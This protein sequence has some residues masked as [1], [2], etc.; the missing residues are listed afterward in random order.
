MLNKNIFI[1]AV[2]IIAISAIL[3]FSNFY[4]SYQQLADAFIKISITPAAIESTKGVFPIGYVQVVKNDGTPQRLS[5]EI[6]IQL[7]SSNPSVATVPEKLVIPANQDVANFEITI[8]HD[9]ETEISANLQNQQVAQKLVVGGTP[10]I[11]PDVGLAINM[12]TTSMNV[13]SEMPASVSLYKNGTAWKS[14]RDLKISLD[15]EKSLLQPESETITIKKGSSYGT[16]TIKS[17]GKTGNAFFKAYSNE[18]GLNNVSKIRVGSSAPSGLIV[19]VFP[20]VLAYTEKY[21]D[22]FVGLVDSN[23]SPTVATEDTKFTFFSNYTDLGESIEE[24][25]APHGPI[26]RKGQFGYHLTQKFTFPSGQARLNGILIG[27]SAPDLG[28]AN[29]TLKIVEP[30]SADSDKAKNKLVKIFTPPKM[31]G[32]TTSILAYQIYAVEDDEDDETKKIQE[33]IELTEE[34]VA[35]AEDTLAEAEDDLAAVQEAATNP[36]SPGGTGITASEQNEIE[37]AEKAVDNAQTALDGANKR[38]DKLNEVLE[39]GDINEHEID[40]LKKGEL[41]PIQSNTVYSSDKLFGNLEVISSDNSL[42]KVDHVSD[43]ITTSSYGTAT[44]S[45][46]QKAGTVKLSA[47]LSGLGSA[48]NSTTIID[49]LKASKTKIFAPSGKDIIFDNEG[50]HDL[51]FILLDSSGNPTKTK[52][53]IRFLIGPSNEFLDISQQESYAKMTISSGI[54]GDRTVNRTTISAVPIGVAAPVSLETNSTFNLV[55]SNSVVKISTPFENIL[56]GTQKD[57]IVQLLDPTGSPLATSEGLRI[58]LLSNNTEVIQVPNLV[59]IPAGRSF[60]HFPITTPGTPG[61]SFVFASSGNFAGSNSKIVVSAS[62]NTM[63]I[64]I[65]PETVP[66]GFNQ[67]TQVKILVDSSTGQPLEGVTVQLVPANGTLASTSVTTD[68][69]GQAIVSFKATAG[70]TASLTAHASKTGYL[71]AQKTK[72]F[73]VSGAQ[74]VA[75]GEFFGI[76]SWA[77]YSAV[78]GAV[79]AIGFVAYMFLKKPKEMATEE[80]EEEI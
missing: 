51:Y 6:E 7:Q 13:N 9:G 18:I 56:Q 63:N 67:D 77:M 66:V 43:I 46:G 5:N 79:G 59:T 34:E 55:H 26:I 8:L 14:S 71:D 45:S 31:P 70:P 74:M 21:L 2:T 60:A 17:L 39:S 48:S 35:L 44:I 37:N 72:E 64:L 22:V 10:P 24:T 42:A 15:Y 78:A 11:P 36:T 3:I 30:L 68:S 75:T 12:P 80:E 41:Y 69:G 62:S 16:T 61:T 29:D 1:F 38:L 58:T 23:G 57:G 25:L 4:I 40:D 65:K 52:D 33:R 50:Y 19:N 53:A 76:P 27:A 47:I 73:E 28:I 54:F 20:D 32:A 49:P